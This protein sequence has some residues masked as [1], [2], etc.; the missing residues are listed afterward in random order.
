ME[1]DKYPERS[2]Y[3]INYRAGNRQSQ[4]IRGVVRTELLKKYSS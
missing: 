2:G 1:A 4:Q 3:A